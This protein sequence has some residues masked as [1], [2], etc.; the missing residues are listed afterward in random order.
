MPRKLTLIRRLPRKSVEGV[1]FRVV[2]KKRATKLLNVAGSLK[3]GGRYN[4]P[5]EFGAI[6]LGESEK[7]CWRELKH[8][9]PKLETEQYVLFAVE[10]KLNCVLD[11]TA[12]KAR[13]RLHLRR[14]QDLIGDDYLLTQRIGAL[15]RKSGFEG[16]LASS[17]T[18]AG[19]ILVVF[20]D[21]LGK[22]S[23]VKLK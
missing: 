22:G 15:A 10:V 20:P 23:Y 19:R 5:E 14:A 13:S 1:F 2:D 4:P 6:Y 3:V 11:L 9:R 16:I 8:R 12:K 21:V 18:Q 7:V 17:A